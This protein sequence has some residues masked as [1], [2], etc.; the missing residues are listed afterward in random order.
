MFSGVHSNTPLKLGIEDK[1]TVGKNQYAQQRE[2][3]LNENDIP[4]VYSYSKY[5]NFTSIWHRRDTPLK[6]SGSAFILVSCAALSQHQD[7]ER[8]VNLS[9]VSVEKSCIY[10]IIQ[11][12]TRCTRRMKRYCNKIHILVY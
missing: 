7:R 9:R 2:R 11:S 8:T 3:V 12:L 10:F 5:S 4:I 1:Y 6:A